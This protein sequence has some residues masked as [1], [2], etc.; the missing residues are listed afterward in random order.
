VWRRRRIG[1][2]IDNP[3]ERVGERKKKGHGSRPG[4]E[5]GCGMMFEMEEV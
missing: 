2:W 4:E 5:I 1:E 3:V